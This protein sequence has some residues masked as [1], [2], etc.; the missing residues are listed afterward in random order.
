[1][2]DQC[3][4]NTS[5]IVGHTSYIINKIF[6]KK[7]NK[8]SKIANFNKWCSSLST[9]NIYHFGTQQG[10]FK[11]FACSFSCFAFIWKYSQWI[12]NKKNIALVWLTRAF[13]IDSFRWISGSSAIRSNPL[14][15]R[16]YIYDN[17]QNKWKSWAYKNLLFSLA[18][19]NVFLGKKKKW[20][21][22]GS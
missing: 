15:M 5:Q 22:I 7:I 21:K 20:W 17:N 10:T 14:M 13:I 12:T 4:L 6:N 1:M 9:F 18:N 3:P 11:Y 2:I 8:F 19:S 16:F